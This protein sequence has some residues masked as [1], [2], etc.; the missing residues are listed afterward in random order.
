MKLMM[1]NLN[2]IIIKKFIKKNYK[3]EKIIRNIL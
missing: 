1:K 2:R 3:K